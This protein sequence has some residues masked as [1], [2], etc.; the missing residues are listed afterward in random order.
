MDK[1]GQIKI[2]LIVE[3][4][5]E[6]H[7]FKQLKKKENIKLEYEIV[8]VKG[9]GYSAILSRLKKE[10]DLGFLAKAI[11]LDYDLAR[12]KPGEKL[13]FKKL[14]LYCIDKNKYGRIPYILIASNFDFEYYACLHSKKYHNTDT[15]KFILDN[16]GYKCIEDYKS[17]AKVYDKLN[18]NGNSY[19]VARNALRKQTN[20]TVV[21]NSCRLTQNGLNIKITNNKLLYTSEADTYM[22]SNMEDL[23]KIIL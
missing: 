20:Q 13:S 5:T 21:S 6:I 23:L 1:S 17:D 10:S 2:Q 12:D 22:N 11:I 9:G 16:F 15:S 18:N 3:G 14:V 19:V 8:N 4:N 7:Y